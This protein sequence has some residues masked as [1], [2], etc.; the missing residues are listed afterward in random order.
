MGLGSVKGGADL[1]SAVAGNY[2]PATLLVGGSHESCFEQHT[3]PAS[4]ELSKTILL[5]SLLIL[6]KFSI[7]VC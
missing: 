5:V 7:I 1:K 2:G 6:G 3:S 4:T